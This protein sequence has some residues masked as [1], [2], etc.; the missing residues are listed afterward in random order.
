MSEITPEERAKVARLSEA[1][2]NRRLIEQLIKLEGWEV[3]TNALADRQQKI[4]TEGVRHGEKSV[5]EVALKSARAEGQL[6]EIENVVKIVNRII[7]DGHEA[8][9]K[10]KELK[11]I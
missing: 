4:A 7:M 11:L 5:D 8:E 1:L 6:L 3:Y 10:L 2:R 9:K